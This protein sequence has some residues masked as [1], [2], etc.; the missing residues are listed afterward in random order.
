MI[1]N[2]QTR[3]PKSSAPNKNK[4]HERQAAQNNVALEASIEAR[5]KA[6]EQERID[7]CAA[8]TAE[9]VNKTVSCVFGARVVKLEG[10]VNFTAGDI[11]K[12]TAVIRDQCVPDTRHTVDRYFAIVEFAG[13]EFAIETSDV[14]IVS[15]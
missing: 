10:T 4:R 13:G 7:R 6:L 9:L 8:L 1:G 5:R 15:I 14:R 2:A 12:V 3:K 11:G